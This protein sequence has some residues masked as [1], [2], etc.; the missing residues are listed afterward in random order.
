MLFC[1][2]HGNGVFQQDNCNFHKTWL[3]TGWLD[4]YSSD[5]SVINWPSISPDLNPIE[6]LWDVLE[7]GVRDHH[8]APTNLTQLWTV[9]ADIWQI[10]SLERFQKCVEFASLWGSRYQDQRRPN[11]LFGRH[12]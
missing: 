12:P 11:L 6:H 4:K 5:F 8:T 1:Y 10:I 2:P 9:L 3:A 7:Q